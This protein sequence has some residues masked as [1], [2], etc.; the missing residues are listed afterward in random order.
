[1]KTLIPLLDFYEPIVN[2]KDG[3]RLLTYRGGRGGSKS[4]GIADALIVRS[5][6]H[7]ERGLVGR[8]VEKAND[9][10]MNRLFE[11]RLMHFYSKGLIPKHFEIMNDRIIF[12]NGGY[13]KFTGFGDKTIENLTSST[14][15]YTW[16]DE[17]HN[18]TERTL[19]RLTPS[20]REENNAV[21]IFSYNPRF[22]SDPITVLSLSR[23]DCLL[24]T[25]NYY[26][27]PYFTSNKALVN[28][29]EQDRGRLERGEISKVKF[30]HIWL[31]Y[32]MTEDDV[33][34]S[35]D[36]LV[37]CEGFESV[38]NHLHKCRIGVDV[39]VSDNDYSVILVRQGNKIH[40]FE[41]YKNLGEK[42][43]AVK[44]ISIRNDLVEKGY[45]DPEIYVDNIGL[46]EGVCEFLKHWNYRYAKADF[47]KNA[48][49]PRYFNKRAE[50]YGRIRNM[51]AEQNIEFP[52][53]S[54]VSKL[55]D[56]L[57]YVLLDV[58]SDRVKIID[59]HIIR[60]KLG[61]SP[62]IADALAVTYYDT[63]N[64]I[65]RKYDTINYDYN[66]NR[67]IEKSKTNEDLTKIW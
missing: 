14:A 46:G 30:N 38:T 33:L 23:S 67:K 3:Y 4:Y 51:M 66:L 56:Q 47:R 26:N 17:C 34:I 5:L 63:T 9:E 42:E 32:P 21:L 57:A 25:V 41:K 7:P 43:L 1:M 55:K 39:G 40:Y 6:S 31:G 64:D 11:K 15:T 58:G 16:V 49:D 65:N 35:Q 50:C 13:I 54:D 19:E 22:I 10:T 20:V 44:I 24:Q 2:N 36:M 29:L 18:I 61:C 52:K 59:K 8:V 53:Q 37:S 27:N 62:D 48:D 12:K 28:E 45:E 60:K